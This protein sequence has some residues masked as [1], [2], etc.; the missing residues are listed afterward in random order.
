MECALR[1]GTEGRLESAAASLELGPFH[2]IHVERDE[3]I[4]GQTASNA[5]RNQIMYEISGR[6]PILEALATNFRSTTQKDWVGK[7]T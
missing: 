6:H 2:L 5:V 4:R 7:G 1:I 3:R